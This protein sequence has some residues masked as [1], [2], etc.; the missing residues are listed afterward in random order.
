MPSHECYFFSITLRAK[1]GA[2]TN[3]MVRFLTLRPKDKVETQL[4]CVGF[5]DCRRLKPRVVY[6]VYLK[7]MMNNECD[8]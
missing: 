2:S 4:F 1:S 7:S 8:L 3:P 6:F 5:P